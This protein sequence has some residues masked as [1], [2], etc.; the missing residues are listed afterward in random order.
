VI[1]DLFAVKSNLTNNRITLVNSG[2]PFFDLLLQ[3]IKDS[4]YVLHLQFYIF[5][6]DSTG[7]LV[8]EELKQ[9][10]K[11]GVAVFVVVDAYASEQIT[12]ENLRL[13][14][15]NG[16]YLKR[17]SPLK[18]KRGYGIGRRLHHKIVWVDGHTALVGGINIADKYSGYHGDTPWL[19]FAVK[20]E[21]PLCNDIKKT[22]DEVIPKRLLKQVYRKL[23]KVVFSDDLPHQSRIRKNDWFR[24]RI[25]ISRSYRQAFR[26][27]KKSIT[28]V[29][30]YFLPGNRVRRLIKNASERGVHVTV[31]LVGNSDVPFIKSAMTY[32]YDWMLRNNV[33][34]YEWN[35]SIL[36]G[37]IAVADGWWTTIG[38][39]NLNALSDYGSLE[40]NVEI[41]NK[42]FATDTEKVLQ[43]Y[44]ETGCKQ[45]KREQHAKAKNWLIQLGRWFSY[46]AIRMALRLLF[47]LMQIRKPSHF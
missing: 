6:L 4:K 41:Y 21:G 31:I 1:N 47:G 36:H 43:Y 46:I 12:P 17:F 16:I 40:L 15:A 39:Y 29:A 2:P 26:L 7:M 3:L 23:P 20:V 10:V 22:C 44:L 13:F 32:L 11:R 5:D 8:L 19:D 33:S 37:K 28:V 30:S 42:Q 34:I 14:S 38:S 25:E 9:A 35:N 27:A 18:N 24:S 45:V